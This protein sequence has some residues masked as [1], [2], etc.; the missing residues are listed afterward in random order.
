MW[1]RAAVRVFEQNSNFAPRSTAPP[2]QQ[3]SAPHPTLSVAGRRERSH[4]IIPWRPTATNC[5]YPSECSHSRQGS[6]RLFSDR[7]E[8][9]PISFAVAEAEK[10]KCAFAHDARLLQAF[11]AKRLH[12]FKCPV[13]VPNADRAVYNWLKST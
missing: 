5:K 12:T 3:I 4:C 10:P 8:L 2:E 11:G 9:A 6:V 13:Q 1:A 7:G